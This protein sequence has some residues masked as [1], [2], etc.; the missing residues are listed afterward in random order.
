MSLFLGII[1]LDQELTQEGVMNIN[2]ALFLILTNMT[3][4]NMF[5]VVNVF[6]VELPIFLREHFNGMYRYEINCLEGLECNVTFN[7]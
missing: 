3:F 6:C 4:Q 2:G 5:G 1:Y 7:P